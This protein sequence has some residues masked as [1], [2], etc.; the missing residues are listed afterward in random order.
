MHRT[1]EAARSAEVALADD[2]QGLAQTLGDLGVTVLVRDE[3]R[4]LVDEEDAVDELQR[5]RRGGER[6]Q[7]LDAVVGLVVGRDAE[8]GLPG[9]GGGLLGGPLRALEHGGLLVGDDVEPDPPAVAVLGEVEV[10]R[11]RGLA[12]HLTGGH[13]LAHTAAVGAVD[14]DGRRPR[15]PYGELH[16]A[17]ARPMLPVRRGERVEVGAEGDAPTGHDPGAVPSQDVAEMRATGDP[18]RFLLDH[19][20]R[21]RV[22]VQREQ[23]GV[24]IERED[25]VLKDVGHREVLRC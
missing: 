24:A 12:G 19:G 17:D 9:A 11:G 16:L 14:E 3:L 8:R 6:P 13:A 15:G 20:P 2:L 1:G 22:C 21:L 7:G 25:D 23:I 18:D 10:E 5:I 4:P